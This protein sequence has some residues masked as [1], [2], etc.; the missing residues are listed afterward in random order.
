M[1]RTTLPVITLS[2]ALALTGCTSATD[3]D[4][5]SPTQSTSSTSASTSTK[6]TPTSTP[7]STSST[8]ST[9]SSSSTS[10]SASTSTAAPANTAA[11]TNFPL[12]LGPDRY[13][14]PHQMFSDPAFVNLF[15]WEDPDF[16][17]DA[18]GQHFQHEGMPMGWCITKTGEV[19]VML[20]HT[21]RDFCRDGANPYEI[22][23]TDCVQ[24]DDWVL[25]ADTNDITD[26]RAA[27]VTA[28]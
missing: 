12:D 28:D 16:G 20:F 14:R 27:A 19:A 2:L 21:T 5:S 25:V 3:A 11:A 23:G 15:N 22:G 4:T 1:P 9:A 13:P 26:L 24:G 6:A 7:S 8:S 18:C 10:A 17:A